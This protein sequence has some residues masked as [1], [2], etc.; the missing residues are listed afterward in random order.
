M[1]SSVLRGPIWGPLLL[2]IYIHDIEEAIKNFKVVIYAD[3]MYLPSLLCSFSM[4]V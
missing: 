4:F 2:I 1:T 3:D